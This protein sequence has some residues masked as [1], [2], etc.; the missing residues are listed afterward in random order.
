MTFISLRSPKSSKVREDMMIAISV[1]FMIR[2]LHCRVDGMFARAR[3]TQIQINNDTFR[4]PKKHNFLIM[5]VSCA[6]S[7]TKKY[8]NIWTE[9]NGFFVTLN[10]YYR[11]AAVLLAAHFWFQLT[12]ILKIVDSY[13]TKM[14]WS[15]LF[16]RAPI[17]LNTVSKLLLNSSMSRAA[18]GKYM[19]DKAFWPTIFRIAE[20]TPKLS[21]SSGESLAATLS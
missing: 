1:R 10:K 20:K 8:S 3:N 4:H 19:L 12:T 17:L 21:C 11:I 7:Q 2:Q 15:W 18:G 13:S 14:G 5:K 6:F 16:F 9:W